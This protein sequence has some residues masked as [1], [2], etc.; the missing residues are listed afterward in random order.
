MENPNE[1]DKYTRKEQKLARLFEDVH[2]NFTLTN[3]ISNFVFFILKYYCSVVSIY[4][5]FSK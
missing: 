4:Y 5:S 2:G 3:V 1:V